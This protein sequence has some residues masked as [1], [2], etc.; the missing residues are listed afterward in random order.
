MSLQIFLAGK[1]GGIEP[2]FYS[3]AEACL[4][5]GEALLARS[6]WVSL[7][8]EIV[9]RALLA[10][11]GLAKI[12]LGASGCGQF[13]VVLPGAA[14]E[15][16]ESFLTRVAGQIA[17]V[18]GGHLRLAWGAT[19]DLGDWS[20]VRRR[21]HDALAPHLAQ[22]VPGPELFEPRMDPPQ[23]EVAD[24][25]L[26]KLYE[27]QRDSAEVGWDPSGECLLTA[28]GAAHSWT[29]NSAGDGFLLPRHAAP[30][31]DGLGGATLETLASRSQGTPAWGVLRGDVDQFGV[32]LRRAQ[33]VEEHI[34]LSV[35]F[36]QFFAGE[37]EVVCSMPEF[38]RKTCI[39]YAGGDD[40][41]VTGSWDALIP[42]AREIQR[43]FHRFSERNLAE[44]PGPEGKTL[45]AGLAV[46]GSSEAEPREVF[47]EAGKNLEIAKAAGPG[48]IHLLGRTLEWK[49][50]QEASEMKDLMAS[51]VVDYGCS[52]Q[53]LLELASFY[54]E[55]SRVPEW[56]GR[57]RS[58]GS[59]F[60]KP[61]RLHRRLSRLLEAPRDREF[62]RLRQ[63]L[64][65][66]LIGKGVSQWRLRPTGRVALEWAR[67]L[68]QVETAQT[69]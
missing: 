17:Q 48:C 67:L 29:I 44:F 20:I 12:L 14:R 1:L 7:L 19:V 62:Q 36:K 34:Q 64:I 15:A 35:L 6:R 53:F 58:R 9:P 39:V 30:S 52:Q 8:S 10:E 37:L 31:D 22:A 69:L 5:A 63:N 25:A 68:T 55:G 3:P 18:S 59:R 66:E 65:G 26:L 47:A 4:D 60:E 16:A 46:A 23:N 49:H 57:S 28:S 56:R 24:A 61:W 45:S 50:L 13:L 40:F 11:L 41:A 2:F 51:L 54:R 27:E 43:L 33:S 38:W 21:L 32:R 42:L